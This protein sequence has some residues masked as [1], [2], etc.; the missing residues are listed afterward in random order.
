MS[1]MEYMMEQQFQASE[2]QQKEDWEQ[3]ENDIQEFIDDN[4]FECTLK[5]VFS[6]F[7]QYKQG[8]NFESFPIA[9]FEKFDDRLTRLVCL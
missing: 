9:I 2:Q 1:Y 5:D 8:F 3:L 4:G 7:K 6:E